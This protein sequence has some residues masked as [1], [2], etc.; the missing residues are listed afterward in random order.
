MQRKVQRLISY[1]CGKESTCGNK[2]NYKSEESATRAAKDLNEKG[3]ARH[4]LEPYQCPFCNGWHV[5]RK[6]F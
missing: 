6:M 5:G 3:K 4:E 2:I 1:L